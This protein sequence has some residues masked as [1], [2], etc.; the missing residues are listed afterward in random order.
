MYTYNTTTCKCICIYALDNS[1]PECDK[2]GL[3]IYCYKHT[4]KLYAY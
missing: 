3:A 1:I 4:M 2:E